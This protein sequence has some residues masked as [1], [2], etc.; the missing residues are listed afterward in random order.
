MTVKELISL[1]RDLPPSAL[2][3]VDDEQCAGSEVIETNSGLAIILWS[4]SKCVD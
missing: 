2:V 3:L 1:L 4:E